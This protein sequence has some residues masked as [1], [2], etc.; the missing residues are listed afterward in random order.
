MPW[1]EVSTQYFY[2]YPSHHYLNYQTSPSISFFT[3]LVPIFMQELEQ[4]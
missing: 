3:L 4:L 1:V 2:H